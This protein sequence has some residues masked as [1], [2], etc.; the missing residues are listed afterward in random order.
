LDLGFGV[1]ALCIDDFEVTVSRYEESSK[2]DSRV[3]NSYDWDCVVSWRGLL[4]LDDGRLFRKLANRSMVVS[5]LAVLNGMVGDSIYDAFHPQPL[6]GSV[7]YQFYAVVI[8]SYIFCDL[9]VLGLGAD[10]KLNH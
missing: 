6:E 8:S 3:S 5:I 4:L 2:Q 7:P 9:S 1:C 10:W